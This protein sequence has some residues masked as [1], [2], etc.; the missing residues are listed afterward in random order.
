MPSS[1]QNSR[2][3]SSCCP[4]RGW[5][6]TLFPSMSFTF[7][8]HNDIMTHWRYV[9]AQAALLVAAE[10]TL[11]AGIWVSSPSFPCHACISALG[12]VNKVSG[13]SKSFCC[14]LQPRLYTGLWG[15]AQCGQNTA[16]QSPS[17]RR[18]AQTFILPQAVLCTC[19]CKR[20]NREVS[21]SV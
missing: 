16:V 19:H 3:P 9:L 12:Q 17:A 2:T 18:Q 1:L 8:Y 6:T 20:G 7:L 15:R 21:M 4:G 10:Q 13:C 11:P 14:L 5:R